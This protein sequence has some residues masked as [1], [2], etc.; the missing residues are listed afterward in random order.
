MNRQTVVSFIIGGVSAN[1]SLQLAMSGHYVIAIVT[2]FMVIAAILNTGI[3]IRR[4]RSW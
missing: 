4:N 2:F 1:C 3:P